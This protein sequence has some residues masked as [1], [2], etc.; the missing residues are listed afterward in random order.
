LHQTHHR[1]IK[2]NKNKINYLNQI[3]KVKVNIYF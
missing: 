3:F 2:P 1:L